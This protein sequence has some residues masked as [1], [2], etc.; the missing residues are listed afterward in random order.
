MLLRVL[1]PITG[2]FITF[3]SNIATLLKDFCAL[4]QKGPKNATI[5][6]AMP[7]CPYVNQ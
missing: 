7:G 1:I 6:V 4:E 5:A 2:V 3:T